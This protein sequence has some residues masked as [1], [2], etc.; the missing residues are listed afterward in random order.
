MNEPTFRASP[1][2]YA[3]KR[4][5]L[6]SFCAC[7]VSAIQI[8]GFEPCA[9]ACTEAQPVAE[10]VFEIAVVGADGLESGGEK[11]CLDPRQ[12]LLD[13]LRQIGTGRGVAAV[14]AV[15]EQIVFR[16]QLVRYPERMQ[17][18]RAGEPSEIGRASC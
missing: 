16:D 10:I 7:A 18:Q 5:M 13:L 4:P 9:F 15:G 17:D 1:K 12:H 2:T 3:A 11:R 6:Q 14:E 8:A